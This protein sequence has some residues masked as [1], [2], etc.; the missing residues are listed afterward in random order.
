M[1]GAEFEMTLEL[2]S[3]LLNLPQDTIIRGVNMSMEQMLDTRTFTVYV[4]HPDLP[5]IPEASIPSIV[6]PSW[7]MVDGKAV[8]VDWGI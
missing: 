3:S 8:F 5:E 2:L 6:S 1:N 7:E 4:E